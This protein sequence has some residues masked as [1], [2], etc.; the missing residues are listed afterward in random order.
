MLQ[1]Q[2]DDGLVHFGHQAPASRRILLIQQSL[3][4]L[5]RDRGAALDDGHGSYVRLEC[6]GHR[7]R[8]D[9]DVVVEAPVLSG[10]CCRHERRR[11]IAARQPHAARLAA[12]ERL[13]ERV[14]VPVDHDR[15]WIRRLVE[16]TA[17]QRAEPQP[18]RAREDHR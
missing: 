1:A 7:D 12:R 13:V 10:E 14:P 11:Q 18:A 17:R 15:R 8:I 6:P 9:A 3:R 2:C 5:L 16:Q 4:D